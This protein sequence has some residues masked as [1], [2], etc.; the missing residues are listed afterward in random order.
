MVALFPCSLLGFA[1][2]LQKGES[3]VSLSPSQTTAMGQAGEP[4]QF[5]GGIGTFLLL[6]SESGILYLGP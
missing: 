1:W 3:L 4:R 5:L 6:R 2:T